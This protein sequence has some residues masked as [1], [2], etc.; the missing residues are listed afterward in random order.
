MRI[1]KSA[2]GRYVEF[3][4]AEIIEEPDP[5][6][7]R[8]LPW[9]IDVFCYPISVPGLTILGIYVFTPVV[10]SLVGLGLSV[11]GYP[12]FL[13]MPLVLAMAAIDLI[14]T[15]YVFW[16]FSMCIHESAV[17]KVRAPETLNKIIADDTTDTILDLLRIVSSVF[18][19][20]GPGLTYYSITQRLDWILWLLL[21][22]GIFFL[23]MALLA[24]VMFGSFDGL[25]PAIVIPSIFNTFLQHCLV[26][27]AFCVPAGIAVGVSVCLPEHTV[28]VFGYILR[29]VSTILTFA[30]G[31]PL[32]LPKH[33]IGIISFLL[34][35]GYA[36]LALVAAHILGIFYYRNKERLYW[37]V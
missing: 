13:S 4:E 17:G 14:V 19:C 12:A 1:G 10:L 15:A 11:V 6:T 3:E 26:L 30:T 9:L 20:V 24:T 7:V 33:N 5:G 37:E 34:R 28:G 35:G 18:I 22:S 32:S 25:N 8:K 2:K 29:G 16:Y 31:L 27:L 21:G 23:P 36:Y